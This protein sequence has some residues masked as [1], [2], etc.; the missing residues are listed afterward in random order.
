[1]AKYLHD[2]PRLSSIFPEAGMII[3]VGMITGGLVR[4][5]TLIDGD[6]TNDDASDYMTALNESN[7]T[8]STIAADLLSF[9]DDT[10]FEI[11]LPP[12]IFNS[13]YHLRRELFYRQIVPICLFAVLGTAISAVV[14]AVMLYWIIQAGWCG[15]AFSPTMIELLTFGSL[16]SA[17][18]PVSTL[19]VFQA[20]AV[21]P[22]LFYLVF[23]ESVLNDAVGLI[24]FLAFASLLEPS[25]DTTANNSVTMF[26]IQFCWTSFMSPL[27]GILYGCCLAF[28]L[29]VIDMRHHVLLEL[30]FYVFSLH[31]P[32][33]L[34]EVFSLSGI[35]VTLFAGISARAYA[36][37]NLSDQCA[38][39]ADLV[40]R[41]VAF[42]AE[43][44]IFLQI[45][46]S[47]FG[48]SGELNIRFALFTLL[49]CLVARAFNVYPITSFFNWS[50]RRKGGD[51]SF[52][53]ERKALQGGQLSFKKP[54]ESSSLLHS[55]IRQSVRTPFQRRDLKIQPHTAHVL[56]FSGLRGAVAYACVRTL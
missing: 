45:G 1:L 15:S 6:T 46:L 4:V 49:A 2:Q 19:A 3:F 34:G 21:D 14:I 53:E 8:A 39:S 43:T 54:S 18:D 38:E 25:S 12:I 56:W 48:L 13:G 40:F 32:Y 28:V 51:M 55:N 47:V 7:S 23:G 9:S 16:I 10:F 44:T 5:L 37:P 35:V 29:K 24:L 33:G 26:A 22:Q 52:D 42:L 41:L 20:K 17:T 31:L 30:C 50:I 27:F 36:A 11:L